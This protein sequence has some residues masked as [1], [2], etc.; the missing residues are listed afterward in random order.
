MIAPY[1]RTVFCYLLSVTSL[2]FAVTWGTSFLGSKAKF[3]RDSMIFP[4]SHTLGVVELSR[5][6][7]LLR[8]TLSFIYQSLQGFKDFSDITDPWET[9]ILN[10]NPSVDSG[11]RADV[12]FS[13]DQ[14]IHLQGPI[15]L[16]CQ[17][18]QSQLLPSFLLYWVLFLSLVLTACWKPTESC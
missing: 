12:Y 18:G 9:H 2:I 14:L 5:R 1:A 4:K 15:S 7:W 8:P 6:L 13:L 16:G 11:I 3:Q 17:K 10:M